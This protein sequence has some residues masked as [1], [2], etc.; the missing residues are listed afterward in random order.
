MP[1]P[2]SVSAPSVL[3]HTSPFRFIPFDRKRVESA[4]TALFV[5]VRAAFRARRLG[6]ALLLACAALGAQA[7][8]AQA[9]YSPGGFGQRGPAPARPRKPQA[10]KPPP[11]Q[12]ETHAASGA[13]DT[14]LPPGGEPRLPEKPLELPPGAKEHLGSDFERS[15]APPALG[16]TQRSFYGL[17]YSEANAEGYGFRSVFPP[18]WFQRKLPSESAP[19]EVDE[20]NLFGP[21]YRRRSAERADDILFPLLWNLRGVEDRTTVVG[22]WVQHRGPERT[23]DW[24]APLYFR[25]TRPG[26]SYTIVPPLLTYLN[27]D[28]LGGLNIAALWFCSWEGSSRCDSDSAE[29]LDQGLAPLYFQGKHRFGDYRLVPPLLHYMR[30]DKRDDSSLAVWGPVYRK[31]TRSEDTLNVYPLYFSKW[32]QTSRST[33]LFPFFH[34]SHDE[35]GSL[36]INPLFVNSTG[37]EGRSTFVSWLYARHR[38]STELDMVSPLYW[39]YRDPAIGLDQKLLVPFYFRKTSP[40]EDSRAYFPFYAKFER[41][42]FSTSRWFSPLVNHRTHLRGWSLR[43][44]PLLYTGRNGQSTHTVVTPLFW[45]FASPNSRSTVGFPVYWRFAEDNSVS[46]LVGNVYY[47]E[48]KVPQGSDWELH[49]FPFFSYGETPDGHF[50]NVLYGLAG[51]TRRGSAT[52]ARTFWVPIQLSE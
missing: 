47:T 2:S 26:G 36:L 48:K 7:A 8:S 51:Y 39:H 43:V 31:H 38:G 41:L 50:W 42:G 16:A 22:P 20:V 17:Y 11:D 35:S 34:K 6:Y 25:G 23:A 40:R 46:Q 27:H 1:R 15:A 9:G 32:S 44:H 33:T 4:L 24:L 19:E 37:P 21:Y 10:K 12:P 3:A 28:P 29:T 30:R 14:L 45:D 52:T 49:V 13:S 18:L 5:A